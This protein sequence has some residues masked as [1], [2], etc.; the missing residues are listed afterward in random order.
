M[1]TERLVFAINTSALRIVCLTLLDVVAIDCG[2]LVVTVT[3]RVWV[4]NIPRCGYVRDGHRI[5][6]V[7]LYETSDRIKVVQVQDR[8]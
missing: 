5:S 8:R 4:N 2:D 1:V 6:L 7:V 3:G